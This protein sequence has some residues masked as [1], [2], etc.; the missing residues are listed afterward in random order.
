MVNGV[1][2]SLEICYVFVGEYFLRSNAKIAVWTWFRPRP[3]LEGRTFVPHEVS[4]CPLTCNLRSA[5]STRNIITA[6]IRTVEA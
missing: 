4:M 1:A 6:P 5:P 3:D 2:A